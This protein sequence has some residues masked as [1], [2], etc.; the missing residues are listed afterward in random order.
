MAQVSHSKKTKPEA[1]RNG[2][3]GR[4]HSGIAL[5]SIRAQLEKILAA[6][7]FSHSERLPRFLRF[8][9]EQ[10]LDGH[11]AELKEYQIGTEVFDRQTSY[12]PRIDPIVRVEAG[13]LRSK[14][15]EFYS[16]EGRND[17]I[18]I[19]LPKGSYVPVFHKRP[20]PVSVPRR[21]LHWLHVLHDAKGRALLVLAVVAAAAIIWNITLLKEKGLLQSQV[22]ASRL[23]KLDREFDLIW[24]RFLAPGATN[25]VVFGSPVFFAAENEMLFLRWGG[26]NDPSAFLN[27]P[28]FERMRKRFGPLSGPRYDY[29]LMGDAT[30]LQRLTA[31]FGR[32]GAS[33]EALPAHQASWETIKDGNVIFLGAP[34]MNPLLERLPVEQDFVWDEDHNVMNRNPQP[35]EQDKYVTV[36]HYDEFTFAV[37]GSFPGLRANRQ[38]LLLT[39][40]SAPGILAAVDYLTQLDSI[41]DLARRLG[42]SD[43]TGEGHFQMLLRVIVDKGAPVKSEYVTHH[44]VVTPPVSP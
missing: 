2:G 7:A 21:V 26:L 6:E 23:G 39:A 14:L 12:D 35:G 22:E 31:F 9:V 37:L 28:E 41:R 18:L 42:T 32:V 33:L 25:F 3:K 34:R 27:D 36:S 5:E 16:A 43:S 29:A 1:I 4:H 40:H 17:L 24:G 44:M 19:D 30:A 13:R 10:E 15:K 38:I 8:A 20:G 11:G